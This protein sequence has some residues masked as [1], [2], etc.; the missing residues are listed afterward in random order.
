MAIG[1]IILGG[2][3]MFYS[4]SETILEASRPH[5]RV[6]KREPDGGE[7]TPSC[8]KCGCPD[9]ITTHSEFW[10]C[11]SCGNQHHTVV[12]ISTEDAGNWRPAE[13]IGLIDA[14]MW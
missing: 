5:K 6:V 11:M 3:G 1:G 9:L 10:E 8:M 12:L 4:S 14:I 2:A 13:R 7:T